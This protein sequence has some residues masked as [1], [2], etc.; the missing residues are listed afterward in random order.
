MVDSAFGEIYLK[1]KLNFYKGIFERTQ[2]REVSLSAS[3]AYAVEVI[4]ALGNP[5]I[6]QFA[7]FLQISKPNATYKVNTLIKKGYIEKIKS[8]IDK[9]E[10]HLHTTPKFMHYYAIN[11]NYII[12]VMQRI[13]ERFSAEELKQFDEM[14]KVISRELMPETDEKLQ[15]ET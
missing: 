6:S 8:D 11:Q 1:F 3:E 15:L 12:V 9:R 5:T 13:K 10:T 4:Y 14:L 2:G 7:Q